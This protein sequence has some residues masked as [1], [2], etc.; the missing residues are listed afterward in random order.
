VPKV[1]GPWTGGQSRPLDRADG[2]DS[3]THKN[4]RGGE[5]STMQKRTADRAP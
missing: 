3:G 4:S 2:R 1:F 5:E